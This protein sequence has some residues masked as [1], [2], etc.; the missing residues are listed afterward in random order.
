MSSDTMENKYEFSEKSYEDTWIV[1][2]FSIKKHRYLERIEDS[3]LQ[4][5]FNL[6]GLNEKVANFK[7]TYMSIQDVANSNDFENES[8]LYLYAHQRYICTKNGMENMLDKVLN[9]EFGRC[10]RKGCVDV[11]LVPLGLSNEYGKYETRLYCYN[12]EN[13]YEARGTL[14]KLDGCAWGTTFAHFLILSYPYN[15]EKKHS[16]KYVPR[17]FGFQVGELDDYDSS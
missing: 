10:G 6:Y 11:P 9:F 7:E 12:C 16:E 4:D 14:R 1:R 17:I 13:V 15:F 5:N 2:F 8:I 3:F